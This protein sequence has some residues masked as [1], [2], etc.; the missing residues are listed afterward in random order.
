MIPTNYEL[1]RMLGIPTR[2]RFKWNKAFQVQLELELLS[3]DRY[4]TALMLKLN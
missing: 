1:S 4:N 3:S 2:K